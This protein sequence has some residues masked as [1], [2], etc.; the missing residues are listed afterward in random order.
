M[1]ED[2]HAAGAGLFLPYSFYR[3]GV[4]SVVHTGILCKVEANVSVCM[5]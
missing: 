2:K 1:S 5:L 3:A 4:V